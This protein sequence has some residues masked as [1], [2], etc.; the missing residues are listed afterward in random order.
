MKCIL[1]QHGQRVEVG[2]FKNMTH[3][4]INVA[5]TLVFLPFFGFLL[6]VVLF[7]VFLPINTFVWFLRF[8]TI[9]KIAREEHIDKQHWSYSTQIFRIMYF[10]DQIIT[11]IDS[12]RMVQAKRLLIKHVK[13]G[14]KITIWWMILE[15]LFFLGMVVV[16]LNFF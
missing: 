16:S 13:R 3:L 11:P 14:W 4:L 5:Q 6:G 8:N 1:A 2:I 15:I 9:S 10:P 7:V 12:E